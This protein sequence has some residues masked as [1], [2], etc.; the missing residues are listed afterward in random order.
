LRLHSR[1]E[2]GD[3]ALGFREPPSKLDFERCDRLMYH[4]GDRAMSRRRTIR[5]ELF[6]T[7]ASSAARPSIEAIDLAAA[8]ACG[9]SDTCIAAY[10]GRIVPRET[11]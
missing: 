10:P 5:F 1:V 6:R 2:R 11:P 7:I 3:W 9:T 8:T 4:A